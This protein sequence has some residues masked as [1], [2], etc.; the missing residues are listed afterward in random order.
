MH[1]YHKFTRPTWAEVSITALQ[2]N[3]ATIRDFVIPS[4]VCAVVK[5]DAYGHG[6][7]EC[8]TALQKENAKWF[9]VT[10]CAEGA[11]LR[12]AGIKGR[13][14]LLS[15]FWKGEEDAVIEHDLTPVI[16]D[17][18]QLKPLEHA[19]KK[20]D[21][22]EVPIHLKVDTGM[23]RLGTALADLPQVVQALHASHSIY[24]EGMCSHFSS[25]E[26]FDGSATED[27][28][29]RFETAYAIV[30]EFGLLPQM[31]HVCNSAG[32]V[33]RP[34]AW[35]ELVR[36]GISLYGYYLPFMSVV[37]GAAESSLELPVV[38]VLSWKTRI[39]AL[40]DLGTKQAIGYG[41]GYV[42]QSPAKIAVIPVGY[43]DG[44]N[45]HLSN[46]GK[47][48][49]HGEFAP[50]VGNVSMDL[51]MIDVTSIPGIAVGDEVTIIGQV[52]EKKITAWDH[53]TLAQTI[54]YEVLCNIN[55][56]VPRVYVD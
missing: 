40:R 2:H 32:I 50:I 23:A 6:T 3:Y 31:V 41:G 22:T 55:A 1:K 33:T 51:T 18:S 19:A 30:T 45:R 49:V 46:H 17:S 4:E 53:A 54:P 39:M 29:L 8:A 12:D 43:G 16:W 11:K 44:L 26:V 27:Q 25:A 34:N 37:T 47:V 28:L 35:K 52:G 48:I 10:D 9:A 20:F 5:A 38:P 21:R 14:L 13:I 56:R 42:T 15:G 24:L 36:P 7:V